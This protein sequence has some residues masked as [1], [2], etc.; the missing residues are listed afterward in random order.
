[1]RRLQSRNSCETYHAS[2]KRGKEVPDGAAASRKL[3]KL[4]QELW[5]GQIVRL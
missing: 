3:R 5:I 4:C 1:M 2:K